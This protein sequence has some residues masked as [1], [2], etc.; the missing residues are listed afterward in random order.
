M[1]F[2]QIVANLS[3]SFNPAIKNKIDPQIANQ[4]SKIAQIIQEEA[5]KKTF[6][7][8]VES[9]KKRDSKSW[10]GNLRSNAMWQKAWRVQ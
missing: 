5:P 2:L 8:N 3:R 10:A 7:D 1:D 4:T 9:F 6:A